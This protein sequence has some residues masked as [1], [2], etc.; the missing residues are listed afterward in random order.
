MLHSG[1]WKIDAEPGLG[2]PTDEKRLRQ[3]GDEGV[4]ALVCDSTNILREGDS[5]SEG[6]VA[7]A[8]R[9]VIAASTG[10]VVVTTFASNVAR[11]RAVAEAAS[12][13]G[14]HVVLV[15]RAMERVVSVARD[16]GYLDGVPDFLGVDAFRP[17]AAR[18]GRADRDRKP[19]RDPRGH[20]AHPEGEHPAV[21]LERGRQ[22][23]FLLAHDPRQ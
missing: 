1:D 13:A 7:G 3:I 10:R 16:C 23:D 5:P 8:L 6:D 20:R 2:A 19:G 15:G 9:D 4:L 21:T 12:A 11:I 22:G 17:S 14:R 18:Q